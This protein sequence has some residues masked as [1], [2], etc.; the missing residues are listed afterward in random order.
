MIQ[1]LSCLEVAPEGFLDDDP[2]PWK[3]VRT[4]DAGSESG[5]RYVFDCSL[6]NTRRNGQIEQT[7]SVPGLHGSLDLLEAPAYRVISLSAGEI[8]I[9]IPDP[10]GQPVPRF[11]V[12]ALHFVR[13]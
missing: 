5:L 12:Y 6:K 1:I 8:A 13:M 2:R 11:V 10:F 3:H 7:V 9:G 4:I